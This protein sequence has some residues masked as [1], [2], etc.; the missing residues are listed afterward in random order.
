M[1]VDSEDQKFFAK[2]LDNQKQLYVEEELSESFGR[3]INF[4]KKAEAR[5]SD[6]ATE[7]GGAHK[8][9]TVDDLVADVEGLVRHFASTW[10]AGISHMSKSIETYFPTTG[11]DM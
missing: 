7:G 5:L 11:M 8:S 6:E 9:V 3:L 2:L 10:K 1:N 4:I